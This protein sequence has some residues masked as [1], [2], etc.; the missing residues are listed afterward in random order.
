MLQGG[1]GDDATRTGA[2]WNGCRHL[3][4]LRGAATL[5]HTVG[6]TLLLV[7]PSYVCLPFLQGYG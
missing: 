7:I 4:S 1:V 3:P 6:F 2:H 5:L